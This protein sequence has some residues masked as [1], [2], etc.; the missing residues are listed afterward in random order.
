MN[1]IYHI[2]RIS[3]FWAFF[4]HD[5]IVNIILYSVIIIITKNQSYQKQ[6]DN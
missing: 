1:A 2:K 6:V 5:P 4:E 3:N